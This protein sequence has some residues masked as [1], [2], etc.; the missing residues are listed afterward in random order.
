MSPSNSASQITHK[1]CLAR[2]SCN[3][4]IWLPYLAWPW[5]LRS[6]RSILIWYQLFIPLEV[7][8]HSL[9]K[10]PLLVQS[11]WPIRR[12]V[13][14]LAF[15]LTLTWHVTFWD[16]FLIAKY[17]SSIAFDC[18]LVHLAMATSSRVRQGGGQISPSPAPQRGAL[19]QISQ[20]GAGLIWVVL[21][22]DKTCNANRS[23]KLLSDS[24]H[25]GIS[26]VSTERKVH[27][28]CIL[29]EYF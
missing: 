7:S 6:I 15:D 3:I 13:T 9:G 4:L 22:E 27:H 2:H 28:G 21:I 1:T 19:G 11:Q 16:F 29:V 17:Y 10:Q 5:P 25:D 20:R 8:W 12:I 24:Q 18:R 26:L 23:Q 14:I